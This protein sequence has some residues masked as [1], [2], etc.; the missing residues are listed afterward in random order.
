MKYY[1]ARN[2]YG[3]NPVMQPEV[4]MELVKRIAARKERELEKSMTL[5]AHL[6]TPPLG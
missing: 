1:S 6:L 3:D 4:T 5:Y 2:Y